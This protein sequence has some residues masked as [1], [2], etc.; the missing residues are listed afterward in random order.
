MINRHVNILKNRSFFLFGARSTGKTTTVKDLFSKDRSKYIDLLQPDIAEEYELNPTA[1]AD[2]LD[3]EK[4]KYDW[5]IIDEIQ[6]NTK[7]LDIVHSYISSS[8][9]KFGLTGSSARKLKRGAANL[10]AGRASVYKLFPLT[11]LE[12]GT[13]FNIQSFL[14]WG[15]LP[16]ITS[17]K[18]ED[19]KFDFLKSYTDTYLKEEILQEQIIRK[20]TPFRRFLNIAAQTNAQI[21]NFSKIARDVGVSTVTVQSYYEILEETLVGKLLEPYH[22]S[23][24]KRQNQNPKFYFFDN[25]VQRALSRQLNIPLNASTYIYGNVFETFVFNQINALNEY[26]RKDFTFSYLKTKDNV[27]IDLIIER[28]GLKTALI[29]IKS[30]KNIREDD[31]KSLARISKDFSNSEAYCFSQDKTPRK[32]K[33]VKCYHW[34][35]GLREIELC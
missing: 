23:I 34:K 15:S 17:L 21:I 8:K 27:E 5:I 25:G 20:L 31:I 35:D 30:S 6:K 24:R 18:S 2:I 13:D 28:P 10:L 29:E 12:L 7:L 14:E 22:S 32:I 16:E 4:D 1:L 33:N 19:E 9:L 26:N 3:I 11:F